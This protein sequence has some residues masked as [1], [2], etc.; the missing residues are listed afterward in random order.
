MNSV[1]ILT[2]AEVLTV[3]ADLKRRAKRSRLSRQNLIVFRLACCCGLRRCEIHGLNLG[4]LVVSGPRPVIRI[5]KEIT[6]GEHGKRKAR[7]VPLWWDSGTLADLSSWVATRR[8][9]GAAPNEPL[10]AQKSGKRIC[11]T[12]L[13]LRWQTAIRKLGPERIS[14]LSIHKGRHS[15]ISHSLH[16]GHGLAEVRDAVGHA[17]VATTNLYAHLVE[18]ETVADLSAEEVK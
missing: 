10:I 1:N 5:R 18:Q 9:D 12:G 2:R 6:K 8:A 4:D 3:L 14:Q 15:F 16:A 11:G 7:L 13:A 17:S